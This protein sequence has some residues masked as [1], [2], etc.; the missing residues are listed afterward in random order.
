MRFLSISAYMMSFTSEV[1][2]AGVTFVIHIPVAQNLGEKQSLAENVQTVGK[3][4]NV[5]FITMT[6]FGM[7][8]FS[9]SF[10]SI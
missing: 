6:L 7:N 10:L 3:L 9:K 1:F 8:L 5:P 2:S 4:L